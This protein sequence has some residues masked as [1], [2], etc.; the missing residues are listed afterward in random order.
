MKFAWKVL[1]PGDEDNYVTI[2]ATI[3]NDTTETTLGLIGMH[4]V[5]STPR[6]PEMVWASFEYSTNNS[7]C[8]SA[9]AVPAGGF[10]FQS[11]ACN[12]CLGQPTEACLKN[13]AFNKAQDNVLTHTGTPSQ[14]CR[15]FPEGTD[16]ANRDNNG[17]KNADGTINNNGAQNIADVTSLNAQLIGPLGSLRALPATNPLRV[18]QLPKSGGH[19]GH[20]SSHIKSA[21]Q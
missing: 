21:L 1:Q 14:I 12:V 11:A 7:N 20:Q 19:L 10:G 5:Q 18:G 3:G 16:L 8:P 9:S 6:H 15:L 4:L 2:D 13:C 17:Q